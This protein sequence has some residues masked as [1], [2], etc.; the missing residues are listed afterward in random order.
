MLKSKKKRRVLPFSCYALILSSQD[1]LMEDNGK[2]DCQFSTRL[3][4]DPIKCGVNSEDFHI[5]RY[6]EMVKPAAGTEETCCYLPNFEEIFG[7]L[8]RRSV[9]KSRRLYT[10][11]RI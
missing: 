7:H 2:G 4:D 1:E 5:F 9:R 6:K 10:E 8:Q 3:L 11:F